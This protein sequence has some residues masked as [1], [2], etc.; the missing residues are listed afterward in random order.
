ML[1]SYQKILRLKKISAKLIFLDENQSYK[2]SDD[3]CHKN[4]FETLILAHFED[5]AL[6]LSTKYNT[7]LEACPILAKNLTNFDPP[8]PCLKLNNLTDTSSDTLQACGNLMQIKC[9]FKLN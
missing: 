8:P 1:W 3:S 6:C 9:K 5:S 4:I 2:D 7:F